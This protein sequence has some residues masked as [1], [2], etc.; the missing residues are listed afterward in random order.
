MLIFL[1]MTECRIK[2]YQ[3]LIAHK[4]MEQKYHKISQIIQKLIFFQRIHYIIWKMK[5]LN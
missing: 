2:E 3:Y 1:Q 4:L 5:I